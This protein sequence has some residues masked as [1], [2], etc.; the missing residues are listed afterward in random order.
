MI[1][2]FHKNNNATQT[3]LRYK[4]SHKTFYKGLVR[5]DGILESLKDKSHKPHNS[6]RAHADAEKVMIKRALKK[7]GWQYQ[8]L[9]FQR[10]LEKGYSVSIK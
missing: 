8:I 10:L 6:P 3:A 9:A 4:V 1:S 5:Y 2:Y 7:V